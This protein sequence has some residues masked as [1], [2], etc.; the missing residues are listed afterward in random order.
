MKRYVLGL[1]FDPSYT[2]VAMIK[3]IK[4]PVG[5]KGKWNGIGGHIEESDFNSYSAMHREFLEETGVNVSEFVWKKFAILEGINWNMACFTYTSDEVF[6]VCTMEREPVQVLPVKELLAKKY[7]VVNNFP[8]L[9]ALALDT[10]S[11]AQP[12]VLYDNSVT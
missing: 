2:Q 3:K 4:G 12:V 9:L 6:R 8:V 1:L 5:V 11:I 10:S 7:D